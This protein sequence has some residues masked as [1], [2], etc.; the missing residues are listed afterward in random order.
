MSSEA[1]SFILDISPSMVKNDT[2]TK[3]I[4]YLEY[5]F[6]EKCKKQ[7]KTDWI[8]CYTANG[9]ET[10]NS[11]GIPNVSNLCT[12]LAPISSDDV[13]SL[14]KEFQR[15]CN[16]IRD[17]SEE[18]E[19]AE[20]MV[21]CLLVA[22]LDMREKFK[23]RKVLKQLMVF[24]DDLDGLNLADEEIDIFVGEIDSRI[25]LID[26]RDENDNNGTNGSGSAWLKLIK[27]LPGSVVYPIN[28]L[29]FEITSPKPAIVKPVRVFSGELKLGAP[30]NK[31]DEDVIQ[32]MEDP[33]CI[34]IK[35]EGYP[36]TKA[37]S[38]LNRK[39]VIKT[40]KTENT[41]AEFTYEPIKSVI[42]YEIK[43]RKEDKPGNDDA[44]GD[45]A[46]VAASQDEDF[47]SITVSQNSITKA[48]RYG[49]DYVV[50]P[51]SLQEQLTYETWPSLDIRG[52]LDKDSLPR[53]L[54][55]SES[56][57]IMPDTRLGSQADNVTFNVL[58]DVLLGQDKVAIARYVPK[59][60]SEV[61]MC[62]LVPLL[63]L[64]EDGKTLIRAFVLNR[65]PFAEDERVADFPR[66]TKR[67]TTSGQPIP[68]KDEDLEKIDSIM[69]EF[70]DSMD[71]DDLPS[72]PAD[73]Y[74]EQIAQN[75]YSTTL[76]LPAD[77]NI[78]KEKTELGE[79]SDP[80]RIPSISVHRQQ[81][82][83]L[84]WIHQKVVMGSDEFIMSDLPDQLREKITPYTSK[85]MDVSG[86]VKMLQIKKIEKASSRGKNEEIP[87]SVNAAP[88]LEELLARGKR[89][90]V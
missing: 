26:C 83:L 50:L 10:S 19:D 27:K 62:V 56:I 75:S 14:L 39:N 44:N 63:V 87:V 76:R 13:V 57:F 38:S 54:L 24:T 7:R 53:Y 68:E 90:D 48:Y 30:C 29:L 88:P 22:S 17:A 80:L 86:L 9:H 71:T 16:S 89:E 58:V 41:S 72:V 33:D 20:S 18:Q 5:T 6:L 52:F 67:K 42:E 43:T 46:E 51:P 8:S 34:S 2:V 21:Q 77:K 60:Y 66:L 4:A 31:T 78:E 79:S 28:D 15:Q 74:Y 73:R 70:I 81:Q 3:A 84:E 12:F 36:A 61:Q 59:Y 45:G 40:P 69:S 82:V 1:T 32:I 85:T 25:I 35:V 37:V 11:Q 65:L 49:A 55:T 47:V 23:K 64:H